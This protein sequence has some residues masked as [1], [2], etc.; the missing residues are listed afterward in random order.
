MRRL[1]T[2]EKLAAL[3]VSAM[4]LTTAAF[5]LLPRGPAK[6]ACA[7]L[8]LAFASA[9]YFLTG[10]RWEGWVAVFGAVG[11]TIYWLVAN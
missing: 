4:A 8:L 1:T 3:C 7:S 6:W 5:C 2:N 9:A 10:K 11:M